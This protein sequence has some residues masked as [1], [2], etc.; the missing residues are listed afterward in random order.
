[1]NVTF[2]KKGNL[3]GVITV[4]LD[5]ADYEDKVT[6]ELKEI[7]KNH[8]IPGFRKGH[9]ELSTLRKRF[10]KETKYRVVNDLAIEQIFKYIED[11]KLDILGRPLPAEGHDFNLDAEDGITFAYEIGLAPE[12]DLH[13]DK[14]TTLKYYNIA[15]SED[16]INDQVKHILQQ[17]GEQVPAQEYAERALVK[18]SM[19]QLDAEGNV[20]PEGIHVE[21]TIIAPF[22][23]KNEE[24]A[25]R[26][27]GTKAGDKVV[28][29]P[30]DTCDG[31]EAE[32]ASMLHIDRDKVESARSNFELTITEFV[33]HKPAEENEELYKKV[34][35]EDVVHNHDEFIQQV[36]AMIEQGLQPNSRQLFVRNTEDYLMETYGASMEL[37][38]RFLKRFM[39]FSD[40]NITDENVDAAY[41]EAAPG[42][43]WELIENKAAEALQVKV[44]EE[45]VKN[46][47]RM[48]AINQLHQYGMGAMADQ[49]ADYYAENILKDD[50]QRR[51]IAQQAFT[52]KLFTAIHNAVN[53]D[54]NT[55]SLDEFRTM[56]QALNN[57]S[58][59]EVAAE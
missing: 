8:Q 34:F 10:G 30:F 41:A 45:D 14:T 25:K 17:A 47:A 5:K 4:T 53:L 54:E 15:V 13:L 7:G 16:M 6:K 18:G 44:E 35:G 58:G 39:M 19:L 27:E 56:V 57:A 49:M 48:F 26:F 28:F 38:E 9:V 24:L 33:V 37:P 23:F 12:L 31:N 40:K 36:T 22:T 50:K 32:V 21:S 2:E 46:F 11:N 42:I 3:E 20:A 55:V 51:Q 43:K 1:M 52:G 59:A 29:N